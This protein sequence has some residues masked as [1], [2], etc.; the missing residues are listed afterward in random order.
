MSPV[1]QRDEFLLQTSD[2]R[3]TGDS[4]D[5]TVDG[6]DFRYVGPSPFFDFRGR[7][8]Y[9]YYQHRRYQEYADSDWFGRAIMMSNAVQQLIKAEGLLRTGDKDGAA[10][11]INITRVGRGGLPPALGSESDSALFDK[12]FYEVSIENYAICSGCAYFNR[13]GWGPLVDTRGSPPGTHHWG[14]VEGTPLHFAMPGDQLQ[15][16]QQPIY[17]YGGVGN[18]GEGLALGPSG[19]AAVGAAK[20]SAAPAWKIYSFNGLETVSE[21]LAYIE[22][23]RTAAR[24][25]REG[26]MRLYR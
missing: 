18:E 15:L 9:S 19:A 7:Y 10:E 21:K 17:T 25:Q 20:G 23:S 24:G 16:L 22:Q 26:V 8:H 1:D 12:L 5:G 4:T 2:A 6:T 3:I 11:I 14:L 13:R